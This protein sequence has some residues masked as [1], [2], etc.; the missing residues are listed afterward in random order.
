MCAPIQSHFFVA[1]DSTKH[2][3]PPNVCH[4][5]QLQLAETVRATS[6]WASSHVWSGGCCCC[7]RCPKSRKLSLGSDNG[8]GNIILATRK[9][10]PKREYGGSRMETFLKRFPA[11]TRPSCPGRPAQPRRPR[12]PGQPCAASFMA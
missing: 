5:D 3:S 11:C 10:R 6:G 2:W 12:W 8:L 4:F 1:Q 7:C 9:F